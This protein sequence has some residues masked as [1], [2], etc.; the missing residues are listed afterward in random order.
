MKTIPAAEFKAHCLALLE[1]VRKTRKPLVVTRHGKA[2]AQITPC[3]S[4]SIAEDNRLKNSVIYES[5]LVSPIGGAW[6]AER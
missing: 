2:V 3:A 4:K 6:E 5:D 1:E